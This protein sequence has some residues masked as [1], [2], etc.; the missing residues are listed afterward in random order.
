MRDSQIFTE[1]TTSLRT[2]HQSLGLCSLSPL[3]SSV[4]FVLRILHP[5]SV[6]GKL[7]SG[8]LGLR[9]LGH[10]AQFAQNLESLTHKHT[11][12]ETLFSCFS[13]N[14]ELIQFSLSFFQNVASLLEYKGSSQKKRHYLGIFPK[15][16][17]PPPLLGAPYQK[18]KVFILHFS[19]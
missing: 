13:E 16:Q 3:D 5:H 11:E 19:P 15:R 1:I 6:L 14:S 9:Q 2:L 12:Q 10:R 4:D 8:Q 7:A 17:T 18:K